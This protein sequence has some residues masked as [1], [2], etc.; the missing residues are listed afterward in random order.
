MTHT[1]AENEPYGLF[2][3][4]FFTLWGAV[5][6]FIQSL[7]KVFCFTNGVTCRGNLYTGITSEAGILTC[8]FSAT[9]DEH[10]LGLG[11]SEPTELEG[12]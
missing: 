4:N 6:R 8:S 1:T 2:F 5:S 10:V 7:K 12:L 11:G 3:V 9:G